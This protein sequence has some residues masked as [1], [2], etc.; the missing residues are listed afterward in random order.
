MR[1]VT[2]RYVINSDLFKEIF[3]SGKRG[4]TPHASNLQLLLPSRHG[5]EG[6]G[7]GFYLPRP[8][9]RFL[10]TYS[11]PYSYPVETRN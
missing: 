7:D 1:N 9:T 5:N 6:G 10:Y 8:R 2:L 4:V 11:L 3:K